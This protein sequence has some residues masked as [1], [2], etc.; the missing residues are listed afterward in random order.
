M[1]IDYNEI[2]SELRSTVKNIEGKPHVR[3][4]RYL[5]TKRYSPTVIKAELHRLA[6]SA[7]HEEPLT[8]YYLAV[9]DPLV[10]K[11]KLGPVYSNYKSKMLKKNPGYAFSKE[12]L[13]YRLTFADHPD[14]QERFCAFITELGIDSIWIS[15][16]MRYYGCASNIP[17]NEHGERIVKT[18]SNKRKLDAILT[19]PKRYLIDKMILEN[20]PDSRIADYVRKEF[21]IQI[22]NYDIEHYKTVFFNMQTFD[23]EGKIRALEVER[24]SL[25]SMLDLLDRDGD[26][27]LGEKMLIRGQ[28]ERRIS[29]L[30][31]NVKTL[32][33]LFSE[34]AFK[35]GQI[36]QGT[37][38]QLFED[39]VQRSYERF[40]L[41]DKYRDRDVV[42]PLFKTAKMMGYALEK[43][44]EINGPGRSSSEKHAQFEMM[45]LYREH[46]E[47]TY[48]KQAAE[49][50]S[51]LE[52][53]DNLMEGEISRD[54]IGGL[55]ELGLNPYE[56]DESIGGDEDE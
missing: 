10:K 19:S 18:T 15:E 43:V 3:F 11:Y 20:V 54:S 50:K 25:T 49:A 38:S 9:I 6:L 13:N 39:I 45:K 14:L 47:K 30:D 51:L 56:G 7:P 17:V 21:K 36:E 2:D 12:L 52:S 16:I 46:A 42:D 35:Q 32:N 26:L 5:L 28:T 31:E 41:L 44:S 8:K 29:E 48:Q 34:M 23:I 22:Y 24:R 4:I 33:A 27:E 53:G 55:D 1:L 40:L 37:M